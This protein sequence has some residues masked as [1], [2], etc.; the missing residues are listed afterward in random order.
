[1]IFQAYHP[2]DTA[3][4]VVLMLVV[5][6]FWLDTNDVVA[7]AGDAMDANTILKRSPKGASKGSGKS[8]DAEFVFCTG[9][10]DSEHPN[11]ARNRNHD[12]GQSKGSREGDSSG[13]NRRDFKCK[14]HKCGKFGLDTY[15]LPGKRAQERLGRVDIA[16]VDLNAPDQCCCPRQIER[17]R[18]GSTR[19]LR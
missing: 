14:C 16:S 6:A 2:K 7:E 17:F 13:K 10:S 3:R 9:K 15:Y 19:V 12:K 8:N 11:V 4:L 5:L 1:M 18:M